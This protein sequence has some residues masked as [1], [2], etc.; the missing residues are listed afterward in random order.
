MCHGHS[1]KTHIRH[2]VHIS[3]CVIDTAQKL[4][5]ANWYISGNVSWTQHKNSR[6]TLGT[7]QKICHKHSTNTQERHLVHIRKC[8]IDTAQKPKKNTWYISEN[9]S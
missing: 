7:Y 2:L 8:V 5:K 6:K 4:R 3:K 9:V 1:T